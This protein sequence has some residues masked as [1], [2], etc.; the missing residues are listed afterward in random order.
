MTEKGQFSI[1]PVLFG[2]IAAFILGSVIYYLSAAYGHDILALLLA[3][4]AGLYLGAAISSRVLKYILIETIPVVILFLISITGLYI[5]VIILSV[6][7]FLHGIWSLFHYPFQKAIN[8]G[9]AFPLSLLAFD[10]GIALFTILFI[11]Y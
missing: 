8:V 7:Y 2:F 10:I 3:A 6:G 5:H 9:V 1:V 4:I 11:T